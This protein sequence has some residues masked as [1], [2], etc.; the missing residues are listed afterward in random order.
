MVSVT[1]ILAA[2]G[3]INT[4]WFDDYHSTRGTYVHRACELL[5]RDEL[6]EAELDSVLVPYVSAWQK[7]KKESGIEI[8]EMETRLTSEVYQ[9]TGKPDR[10]VKWNGYP[11]II[12]IKSGVVQPWTA[13]QLA[14]YEILKGS[15]HKRVGIQLTDES[16]YKITEFKDRQDRQ[17]FLSALACYY[18]KANNNIGR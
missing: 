17:I 6:E 8:I 3:F 10:I 9:F 16:T 7:F 14:G 4:L 13:L 5:D 12:D 2:E 1:Q 11:T 18:W 15:P